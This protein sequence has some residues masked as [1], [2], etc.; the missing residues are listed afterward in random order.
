[1]ARSLLLSLVCLALPAFASG[2]EAPGRHLDAQA[3]EGQLRALAGAAPERAR[4]VEYG[5]SLGG[6][7]LL[8]LEIGN[9]ATPGW[10]LVGGLDGRRLSESTALLETARAL[11]AGEHDEALAG[12]SVAIIPR[13]NPD[14]AESHFG[15]L[16][17]AFERAGNGRP[18]DADHDGR[19]DEDAPA[20]L[21]GDGAITWMRVPDNEG[22][23]VI[24]AHDPRALRKA[25][26]E[27]GE[28]GTH[29]LLR[30]GR[31]ADR[32]GAY[33]E[34]DLDGAQID[35][36]FPHRFAEHDTASGRWPLS[37]PEAR[38]L[39]DYLLERPRLAGVLV[40]G[41]SDSLLE[42]PAKAKSGRASAEGVSEQL[43]GLLEDDVATLKELGRRFKAALGEVKH[44]PKGGGLPD[45]SFVA[46][47][48]HQ[49]GRWPLALKVWE[50][51]AELPK[52]KAKE[53]DGGAQTDGDAD[54]PKGDEAAAEPAA[55]AAKHARGSS[56]SSDEDPPTSDASSPVPAALLAW[57]DA[58]RGG[59]GIVPWTAFEHA[60]LGTVEIGGLLPRVLF[61]PPVET[62]ATFGR[63][64]APFVGELLGALPDIAFESVE[65][66]ADA[67]G[68]YTLSAAL[69]NRGVLPSA[70]AMG[71]GAELRA[72]FV[73]GLQLPDDCRRVSGPAQQIVDRLPG[74][75]GRHE[76]RWTI[77]G[78]PGQVVLLLADSSA[79]PGA[80]VE[81]TLP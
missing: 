79:L 62:A 75:G 71:A 42:A 29:R 30:E 76:L 2:Q 11:L 4:V 40:L 28:R 48:Y 70:S 52:A 44:E 61:D 8:A 15:A 20:D 63:R 34:D 81:V 14:G 51:P 9:V 31:D 49:A 78:L 1:M 22:A 21:D 47:A 46:W 35:R 41:G 3:L 19:V 24:D 39:A 45:G 26:T 73:V 43:D 7:P 64:L 77:A 66:R 60:Q 54:E 56:T 59:F 74:G 72:P 50:A 18:D 6:R 80:L 36:N 33:V 12:R 68:L 67:P 37:E 16:G 57:L 38:A 69:V 27:R 25:R 23:W 13:A 55:D 65:L 32:D 53:K 58:E 5:R 10:L 17:P